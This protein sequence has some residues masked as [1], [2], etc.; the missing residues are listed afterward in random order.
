MDSI[1]RDRRQAAL[2]FRKSSSRGRLHWYQIA[3]IDRSSG[4]GFISTDDAAFRGGRT[5][6][7]VQ[8]ASL[9]TLAEVLPSSERTSEPCRAPITM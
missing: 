6:V 4:G 5:T 1:L 2:I 3:G 8:S 7:T 9:A